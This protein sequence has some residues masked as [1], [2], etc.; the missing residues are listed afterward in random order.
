[1]P[2][3]QQKI[4]GCST[5]QISDV[6][7]LMP[8]YSICSSQMEGVGI[9]YSCTLPKWHSNVHNIFATGQEYLWIQFISLL[10]SHSKVESKSVIRNFKHS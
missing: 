4:K 7:C 3:S 1:M 9:A 5:Y 10:T 8:G 2:C 6:S